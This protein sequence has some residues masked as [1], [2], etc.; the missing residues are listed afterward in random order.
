MKNI[1][2]TLIA[3]FVFS[4]S[5]LAISPKKNTIDVEVV[6]SGDIASMLQFDSTTN[7]VKLPL[8][9]SYKTPLSKLVELQISNPYPGKFTITYE[10]PD[11]D[12]INVVVKDTDQNLKYT[13]IFSA[14]SQFIYKIIISKI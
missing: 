4:Y 11:N 12:N 1:L 3:V 14:N 10:T 6:Y 9:I 5:S 7:N 8:G 13:M 2:F